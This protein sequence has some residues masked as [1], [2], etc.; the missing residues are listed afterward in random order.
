MI[1]L[2]DL[3]WDTIILTFINVIDTENPQNG[4]VN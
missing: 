4:R 3:P 1:G 2:Y